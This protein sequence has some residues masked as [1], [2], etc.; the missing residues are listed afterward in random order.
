MALCG[1][2]GWRVFEQGKSLMVE[3]DGYL[4]ALLAQAA[5]EEEFLCRLH[6]ASN[7]PVEVAG[8]EPAA[9]PAVFLM[10]T[11]QQRVELRDRGFSVEAIRRMTPAEAHEHLGLSRPSAQSGTP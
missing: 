9:P 7:R 3:T 4:R 2:R 6:Q 5:T 8:K 11:H 10:I 1:A